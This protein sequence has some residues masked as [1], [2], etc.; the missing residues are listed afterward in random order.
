MYIL[1]SSDSEE[2]D[3]PGGDVLSI[4]EVSMAIS[5]L[6]RADVCRLRKAARFLAGIN[7][8]NDDGELLQE[9]LV[10]AYEG[11]RKCRRDLPILTFL[12]GAMR[13]IANSAAKSARRSPVDRFVSVSDDFDDAADSG[14]FAEG[15]DFVTPEREEVARNMLQKIQDVFKDDEESQ[16]LLY[17]IGEG[18]KGQGLRAELGLSETQENTIRTRISRKLDEWLAEEWRAK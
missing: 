15:V 12:I 5:A 2:P 7:G 9:A 14:P 8:L 1:A 16:M 11:R 3:D 13:S 18:F 17:A 10:R 4:G 6:S